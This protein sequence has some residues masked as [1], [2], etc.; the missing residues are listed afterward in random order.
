[1]NEDESDRLID[2]V[3]RLR[4][5]LIALRAAAQVAEATALGADIATL[6]YACEALHQRLLVELGVS[7]ASAA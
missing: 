4:T 1:M 2:A 5:A 6:S 3:V 7:H